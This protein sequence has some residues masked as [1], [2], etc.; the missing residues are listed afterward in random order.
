MTLSVRFRGSS[1]V[2][3]PT[4]QMARGVML[5]L[6][7]HRRTN[8]VHR[9]SVRMIFYFVTKC[10]S[11]SRVQAVRRSHTFAGNLVF[12]GGTKGLSQRLPTPRVGRLR[13]VHFVVFGW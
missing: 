4:V 3:Y 2:S 1:V 7:S 5:D 12:K 8:V 10:F 9:R 13:I 11:L 6:T